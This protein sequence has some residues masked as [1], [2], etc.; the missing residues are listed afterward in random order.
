MTTTPA[1]T[2]DPIRNVVRKVYTEFPEMRE[3][4][5]NPL[6]RS[7]LFNLLLPL[8]AAGQRHTF[9]QCVQQVYR[10]G[11]YVSK[12]PP[13]VP[14]RQRANDHET[15]VIAAQSVE[16]RANSQK[17][18]LLSAFV[19]AGEEG[20]T[21]IEAC[22]AANLSEKS[23]Y[24][25]RVSELNATGMVERMEDIHGVTVT[26]PGDYGSPREVYVVTALGRGRAATTEDV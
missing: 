9:E 7:T 5:M 6:R 17:A 24:W 11:Y 19:V 22:R 16:F 3:A 8:V 21:A 20:L 18:K 15:S 13:L 14:P 4:L 10:G 25:K 2:E 23:C 26:R 12:N 1:G